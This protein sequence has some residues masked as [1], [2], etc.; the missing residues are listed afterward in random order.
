MVKAKEE[1]KQAYNKDFYKWLQETRETIKS[2]KLENLDTEGILEVI[3]DMS[4]TLER[5]L[6]SFIMRLMVHIYKWEN[7]P[8]K[9]SKSW[10]FSIISSQKEIKSLLEKNP[11]LKG[12]VEDLIQEA[13]DKATDWIVAETNLEYEDL[14]EKCPYTFDYIISFFPDKEDLAKWPY[15]T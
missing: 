6:E 9:R 11:S 7:F 2:G 14:P 13:W 8:E 12:K 1:L 3:E 15:N 10:R 4:R 5:K